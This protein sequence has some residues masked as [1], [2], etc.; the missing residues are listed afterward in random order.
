MKL[1]MVTLVAMGLA[2]PSSALSQES[3]NSLS[4]CWSDNTSVKECPPPPPTCVLPEPKKKRKWKPR[5]PCTC[6][7]DQGEVGPEGP[8][9]ETGV[10]T[11]RIVE[12]VLPPHDH[13][14][15][16]EDAAFR[17]GL[18]WMGTSL[19]PARDYAWAQ[20][21]S[22]RLT[23]GLSGEHT[24]NL[25]VGWGPGRDGALTVRATL[26][27]WDFLLDEEWIGLGGGLLWESIG[28][29]EGRPEGTYVGLLGEIS[30]R[31]EVI[32][33]VTLSANVGPVLAYA[34][35]DDPQDTKDLTLGLAGSAGASFRF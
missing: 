29:V 10:I 14:H 35:F 33:W 24:A 21:P 11:I 5:K 22:L 1:F 12:E 6:T 31:H 27:D 28:R 17:L 7:G 19:W 9:G 4:V 26:T 8:P 32:S 15:A 2:L 18:G 25:E 20:G 13:D 16:H 3:E 34:W 30:I 23:S